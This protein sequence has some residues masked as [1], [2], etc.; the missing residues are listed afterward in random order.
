MGPAPSASIVHRDIQTAKPCRSGRPGADVIFVADVGIDELG[1]GRKAQFLAAPCQPRHADQRTIAPYGEG[2]GGGA[3]R[4]RQT[5]INATGVLMIN[6]RSCRLSFKAV[7]R[8]CVSPGFPSP[9]WSRSWVLVVQR[10]RLC[11]LVSIPL[12]HRTL[13]TETS[14]IF[15]AAPRRAASGC[16]KAYTRLSRP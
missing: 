16:G 9:S 10:E 13:I 12:R 4:C 2:N 3:R 11:R 7:R 1:T 8:R 5:G 6:S 15:R 14:S